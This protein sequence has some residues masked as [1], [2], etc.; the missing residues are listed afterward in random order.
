MSGPAKARSELGHGRQAIRLSEK[1][2]GYLIERCA[3][4]SLGPEEGTRMSGREKARYAYLY[5]RMTRVYFVKVDDEIVGYFECSDDPVFFLEGGE[6]GKRYSTICLRFLESKPSVDIG[7][8]VSLFLELTRGSRK[9]GQNLLYAAGDG[10][11]F[12]GEFLGHLAA[13]G[14]R[15]VAQGEIPGKVI[16]KADR[17]SA[18]FGIPNAYRQANIHVLARKGGQ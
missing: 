3:M 4:T 17:M 10:K 15:P 16:E 14:F 18:R 2:D 9:D 8:L 12:E 13:A 1:K 11:G 5:R 7:D 6:Y